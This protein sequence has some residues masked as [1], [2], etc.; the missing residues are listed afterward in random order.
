M[1]RTLRGRIWQSLAATTF[2]RIVHVGYVF[3]LVP[4]L[5]G[6]WGVEIYGEWVI[7]T[8][9]A[10]FGSLTNV[11]IVQ[12]SAS[13]IMLAVG[14][15]DR[16]RASRISVTT[17][18]SGIGFNIA[19][20]GLTWIALTRLDV[21]ALLG[22][23]I[24]SRDAAISILML[25][26]ASI[27]LSVFVPPLSSA[28]AVARGNGLTTLVGAL[29]KICELVLIG[30]AA[31]VGGGPV[32]VTSVFVIATLM[33][34]VVYF[35][36]V[37]RFVSWL[38]F[39]LKYF[40]LAILRGL[41]RPSLA[42][43]IIYISTNIL[44]IQVPRI[45]L[46]HLAGPVAV[47]GF[48]VSVTYTRALRTLTT[49]FSQSLQVETPR[50]FAEQKPEVLLRIVTALCQINLWISIVFLIALISLGSSIF[51]LW[52]HGRIQFDVGLCV[53]LGIAAVI[54]SYS[55]V[56]STFLIGI[57]RIMA[58]ALAH[59]VATVLAL[60]LA[61]LLIPIWGVDSMAAVLIAPE[62]ATAVVG[63]LVFSRLLSL[64]P[65]EFFMSTL[66]LPAEVI[67]RELEHVAKIVKR[68]K[69]G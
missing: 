50:A 8:A 39:D 66:Q 41:M 3:V 69:V 30:V 35:F 44:A 62:M 56:I 10:S 11:G 68:W 63:I 45:I 4:L 13:E 47:A 38:S 58:V 24:I 55:D 46:G 34:I 33:N 31:L 52:T 19:I 2:A 37:R 23:S 16:E 53:L 6:A 14:A 49:L 22:V 40:D 5:L 54:G 12:A 36:L 7:L 18:V 28:L 1:K 51:S 65:M 25:S 48:T 43:F 64:R 27:V 9:I 57:N 61:E 26:L 21:S 17:L 29:I 15:G 20:L 32:W 67:Q 42:Q 60:G 59:L